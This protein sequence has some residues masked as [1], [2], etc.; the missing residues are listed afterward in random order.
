MLGSTSPAY[1]RA[2]TAVAVLVGLVLWVVTENFGMI[3]SSGAT[4]PNSGPLI[5]LLALS[6]WPVGTRPVGEPTIVAMA[7]VPA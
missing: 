2:A 5:V 7:E 3:L 4:D 6:F 1:A